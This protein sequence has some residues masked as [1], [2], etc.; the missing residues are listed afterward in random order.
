MPIRI[1]YS[2]KRLRKAIT[3]KSSRA[4]RARGQ[5]SPLVRRSRTSLA[6]LRAKRKRTIRVWRRDKRSFFSACHGP[7]SCRRTL[8]G[9]FEHATSWESRDSRCVRLVPPAFYLLSGL[10]TTISYPP[11]HACPSSCALALRARTRGFAGYSRFPRLT[12]PLDKQLLTGSGPARRLRAYYDYDGRL[13]SEL[14]W[15]YAAPELP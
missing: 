9:R 5:S 2:I 3:T 7:P 11:G 12:T 15:L 10:I 14:P 8:K 6:R 1:Y 13:M 4:N